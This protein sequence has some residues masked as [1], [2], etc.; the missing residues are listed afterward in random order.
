[1]VSTEHDLQK[2]IVELL[3]RFGFFVFETDVM[4]GLKFCSTNNMRMAFINHHKKMG[5]VKGQ[6][7]LV[8]LKNGRV[9][10]VELKRGKDG[11]QSKEQK[12]FEKVVKDNLFEYII[13]RNYVDAYD[14]CKKIKKYKK[15]Y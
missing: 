8:V 9:W 15:M 4:D 10:F 1:M 2:S 6:S 5:Y 13:F 11:R 14:F 7:D 3:R 12:E